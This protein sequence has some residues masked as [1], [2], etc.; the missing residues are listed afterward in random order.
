MMAAKLH[1]GNGDC[2]YDFGG[3][4]SGASWRGGRDGDGVVFYRANGDG[5]DYTHQFAHTKYVYG[6]WDE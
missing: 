5:A 2:P 4:G 1:D 3:N 6:E